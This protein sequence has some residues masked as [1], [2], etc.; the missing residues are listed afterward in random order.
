MMKTKSPN[1]VIPSEAQRSLGIPMR[2][3][4]S[5]TTGPLGCAR[6]DT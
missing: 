2:K 6:D 1:S 3:L 5:N 4:K